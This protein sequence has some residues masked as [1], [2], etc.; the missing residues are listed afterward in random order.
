[1]IELHKALSKTKK[2]NKT[3]YNKFESEQIYTIL[4]YHVLKRSTKK[5]LFLI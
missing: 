4:K 5:N 1:M 2:S 3:F